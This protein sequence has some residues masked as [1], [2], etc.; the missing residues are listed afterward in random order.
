MGR[1]E[2]MGQKFEQVIEFARRA[3]DPP[4]IVTALAAPAIG[5]LM[6]WVFLLGNEGHPLSY[7][8]YVLSA[9]LLMVLCF[10]AVRRFPREGLR[11]LAAKNR[12]TEQAMDDADYRRRLFVALDVFM[13]VLWAA[14]NLIGGILSP[15]VWLITLGAFYFLCAVMRA[16]V[17][18]HMGSS[19]A[20]K[21]RQA[22]A[23]ER[24]C[25]VLLLLSVFVLSGIVCL[26][27]KGEGGF[28][29]EGYL[30]YAVAAFAFYSLIVSIVNYAR[31]RKHEDRLV[32]VNCRINLSVALVSIFALEVA[33]LAQFST[34]SDVELNFFAPIATGTVVAIVIAAMGIRSI[35][36]ARTCTSE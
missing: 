17:F 19:G 25:G 33:M 27:M 22:S 15:S 24:L 14:V 1:F 4:P 11:A 5:A 30:I 10:W 18:R 3:L 23:V 31:L 12:M 2:G 34:A 20:R 6:A 32:V 26:V 7:A 13:D 16:V 36:A 21:T 29:Y 8:A 35:A 28:A 9:Y